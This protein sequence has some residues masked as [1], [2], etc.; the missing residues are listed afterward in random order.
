MEVRCTQCGASL[1]VPADARL[2]QCSF[3]S[4]AL[5]VDPE[6]VLFREALLPTVSPGEVAAHLR[7]FLASDDTVAGLDREAKVGDPALVMFPF[8]GFTVGEERRERTV[9]MPAAPSTLQGLHGLALPAGEAAPPGAQLPGP[10]GEPEVPLATARQWLEQREAQVRVRRTVLY[11]LPLYKVSYSWRGRT[12]TAAVDGVSGR[13]YPAD[14]P[15]K[16][17]APYVLVAGLA[18]AVFGLEGLV[19]GSIV[20]KA[21][22]YLVSAVPLMGLAWWVTRKV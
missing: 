10:L 6:G 3:C 4:T 11:H 16:A 13:V 20:L 8:W 7:R 15:S 5:V 21:L 2:L 9:L 14:F 17:E 18:L 12:Y 22:V 19:I 1:S